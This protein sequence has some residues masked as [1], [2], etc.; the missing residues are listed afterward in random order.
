M[1]FAYY[2]WYRV[3]ADDRETETVIRQMLARLVCRGGISGR[4]LKKHDEPRLWMEVYEGILDP[5][6]FLRLLQ[7]AED[8]YDVAMFCENTRHTE[9]F[10]QDDAAQ[11]TAS[12]V[13]RAP[14]GSGGVS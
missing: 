3:R 8:E 2:I 6:A 1:S 12:C 10:V 5:D 13:S 9:C 4:L 11:A 14:P 7:Q